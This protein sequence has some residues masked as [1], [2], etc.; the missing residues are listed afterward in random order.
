[1]KNISVTLQKDSIS[2]GERTVML[3]DGRK[4]KTLILIGKQLHTL[5]VYQFFGSYDGK[6]RWFVLNDHSDIVEIEES[7]A[8]KESCPSFKEERKIY[9]I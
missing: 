9:A 5:S 3:L 6:L 7:V 8:L 2:L 4:V 1:M